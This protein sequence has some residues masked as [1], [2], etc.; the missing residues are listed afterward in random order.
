MSKFIYKWLV[1]DGRYALQGQ[2]NHPEDNP[3]NAETDAEKLLPKLYIPLGRQNSKQ[4]PPSIVVATA[5]SVR[6]IKIVESPDHCM[7]IKVQLKRLKKADGSWNIKSLMLRV[8]QN[9]DAPSQNKSV[10]NEILPKEKLVYQEILRK[11]QI[12]QLPEDS[13]KTKDTNLPTIANPLLIWADKTIDAEQP[14]QS[15]FKIRIW[16]STK[17]NA[18]GQ[19]GKDLLPFID[20]PDASY[21]IQVHDQYHPSEQ[22]F[23]DKF[24]LD[25]RSD[26]WDEF[27]KRRRDKAKVGKYDNKVGRNITELSYRTFMAPAAETE[28]VQI[29]LEEAAKTGTPFTEALMEVAKS[30]VVSQ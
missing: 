19:E 15:P 12:E 4:P 10:S 20:E 29:A 14:V 16:V 8:Y 18:F 3:G 28:L 23:S 21:T 26:T 6:L 2:C 7:A 30:S 22:E 1:W 27:I 24:K 25:G 13:E 9:Y 11:E 17:K 5:V